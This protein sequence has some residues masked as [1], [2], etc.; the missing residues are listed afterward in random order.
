MRQ[1]RLF[2][3]VVVLASGALVH[4]SSGPTEDGA[5]DLGASAISSADARVLV[6]LRLTAYGDQ[7]RVLTGRGYDVAGVNLNTSEVDLLVGS[8]DLDR[9]QADGFVV[10]RV[11]QPDEEAQAPDLTKY[12]T[13]DTVASTLKGYAERYPTLAQSTSIGLSTQGRDIFAMRITKDVGAPHAPRPAVLFNG[14]HHARE[15]MTAEVGLDTIDYL[16]TRYG[17]DPK[18]THWVDANEIWVIPMLNVD[19]NNQVWTN[20]KMW[21]KNTHGC[22]GSA[23]CQRGSGVDINRNY[24]YKF[25]GCNGSSSSPMAEDY[26]GPSGGSEPETQAL[27]HLVDQTRPVF[28]ISY[29][30]YSEVVLYPTGC[31]GTHAATRAVFEDIGGKM[32]AALPSDD[33]VHNYQAGTPWELLYGVDGD[34]F[35]WMYQEYSVAGFAIEM[36]ST[37]QGFQPS[38]TQ[39]RDRTVTKIRAAWQMLLDRLD[40]SG[41][42]G[43]VHSSSG[44]MVAGAQ[45]SVAGASRAVNPDGSFHV[46]LLPGEYDVTVSATGHAPVTRHVTVADQRVDLDLSID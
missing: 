1:R 18:V 15:L 43:F 29:H 11:R 44:A 16:L 8:A 45:V 4:C 39:W 9:I 14:M 5:A 23:A 12:Q 6:T 3:I 46:V 10:V 31:E 33:G 21:R 35:D 27:M 37:A 42:R 41:V 20:D 25:A 2:S 7:M 34:D 30:S 28:D 32:A 36:N 38:F 26:H 22:T 13:P 19:G 17:T 40:T 24:P